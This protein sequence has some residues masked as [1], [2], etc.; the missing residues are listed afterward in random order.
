MSKKPVTYA[1]IFA[2]GGSKGLPKKNIRPLNKIPLIAHAIKIGLNSPLI[3]KLF[4]STD[5]EEIAKIAQQY[6]AEV[7]FIRPPE[8]ASDT[9]PERLA[10]RHAVEWVKTSKHTDME[11]MISLP[12]TSPLRTLDEVN[13]GI[14]YFYKG[15]WETVLAVSPSNRHP[16]FNVINMNKK[17]EVSLVNPPNIKGARRQ[18]FDPVYDITTAFYVTTPDFVLKYDSFWDG[19][20]GAIEIPVEHAVDIDCEF[21]FKFAEFLLKEKGRINENN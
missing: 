9:A 15:G 12:S 20:V 10:W 3:D 1:W 2:R 5:D 19:R 11:V 16:S 17:G 7:P 18:D 13:Q 8:L 4:I 6:G 14:N 21:D